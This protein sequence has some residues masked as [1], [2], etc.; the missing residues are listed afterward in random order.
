MRSSAASRSNLPPE[1]DEWVV[2]ESRRLTAGEPTI[3]ALVERFASGSPGSQSN[4]KERGK[5]SSVRRPIAALV[6]VALVSMAIGLLL[7]WQGAPG[8]LQGDNAT[9]KAI[10]E[11]VLS[12]PAKLEAKIGE[13]IDFAIAVDS[14][15]ALPARSLIAISGMPDGASF[16]QGRPYGMTGWSLRPDEIGDLQLRLTNAQTGAFDMRIELLAADG[17]PLAQSETRFNIASDPIE[18]EAVSA[19]QSGSLREIAQAIEASAPAEPLPPSPQRK[20]AHSAKTEPSLD[21]TTVKVVTVKPAA[22]ARPHDGAYALGVAADNP[23]EWV[24][25]VSAVDVHAGP[26]QSSA[27]VK[28]VEKGLKLQVTA[29]DKNWVQVL[30]PATSTKGWIY[31]RFLKPSEP[32]A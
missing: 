9:P 4:V 20:P 10:P 7:L 13:E 18:G 12:S 26:E 28:V 25:I 30:D 21:I 24:E 17:A 5:A 29:R 8:Y 32:P 2:P 14:T 3:S 31:K 11:I 6:T 1:D 22:S 19:V 23:A 15:E 16:S 27:T